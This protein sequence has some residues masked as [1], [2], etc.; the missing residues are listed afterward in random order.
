VSNQGQ[1]Q[2]R[3]LAEFMQFGFNAKAQRLKGAKGAGGNDSL[4]NDHRLVAS[5]GFGKIL[6]APWRLCALALKFWRF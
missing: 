3:F 4:T 1:L 6:F 2:N 5:T